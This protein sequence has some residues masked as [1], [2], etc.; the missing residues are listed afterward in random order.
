ML[1]D[2]LLN[3][4]HRRAPVPWCIKEHP[5]MAFVLPKIAH[6]L[7][8]FHRDWFPSMNLPLSDGKHKQLLDI[9][10][11]ALYQRLQTLPGGRGEVG[12][13]SSLYVGH[14]SFMGNQI[15]HCTPFASQHSLN[16]L[17][18][19]CTV[20]PRP[21]LQGPRKKFDFN[22]DSAWYGRVELL[23][24]VHVRTDSGDVME[25]KCAALSTLY[26][27]D[28]S[29]PA[30]TWWQNTSHDQ[31]KLVYLPVM[32]EPV[33]YIVPIT[34]ILGRLPLIPAGETGTIPHGTASRKFPRGKAD[35]ALSPGSGSPLFYI[36]T[37][38]MQWP[39]DYPTSGSQ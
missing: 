4:A 15:V 27:F 21:F 3:R 35:S 9:H 20:P 37:W 10:F 31:T 33:L 28:P 25:C 16:R 24:K 11:N 18:F 17:D 19:V 5:V 2:P 12:V 30:K 39:S 22:L 13:Y 14:T 36:N 7:N 6:F 32:P 26:D 1:S 29:G 23:F 34:H 8:D 38:A